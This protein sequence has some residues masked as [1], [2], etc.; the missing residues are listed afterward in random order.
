M[1]RSNFLITLCHAGGARTGEGGREKGRICLVAALLEAEEG[2]AVQLA[3]LARGLLVDQAAERIV[4]RQD[5][6]VST[7]SC[8]SCCAFPYKTTQWVMQTSSKRP[9]EWLPGR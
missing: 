1:V 6:P 8:E 2:L 3:V 5:V 4:L 7:C 9:W